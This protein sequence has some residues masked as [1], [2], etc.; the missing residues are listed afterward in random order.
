MSK[1]VKLDMRRSKIVFVKLPIFTNVAWC[2]CDMI[3]R[4]QPACKKALNEWE[5]QGSIA[6]PPSGRT[7]IPNW[8]N[9][10]AGQSKAT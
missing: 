4:G 7:Q 2:P 6:A 9:L 1:N 8:E 5:G 3:T 10:L